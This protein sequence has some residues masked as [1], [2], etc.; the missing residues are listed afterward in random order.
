MSGPLLFILVLSLLVI[1]H[2]W[3]HYFAARRCGIRVER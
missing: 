2:E 3:G 1:V